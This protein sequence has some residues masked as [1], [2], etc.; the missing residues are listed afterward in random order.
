MGQIQPYGCIDAMSFGLEWPHCLYLE[1]AA[2]EPSRVVAITRFQSYTPI[3]SSFASRHEVTQPTCRLTHEETF[4]PVFK[5]ALV[6]T[7]KLLGFL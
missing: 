1:I 4:N 6:M 7:Q 2:C 3:Q 5:R